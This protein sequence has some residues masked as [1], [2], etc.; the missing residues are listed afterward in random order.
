MLAWGFGWI[1]PGA[2]QLQADNQTQA[3]IVAVAAPDCVTRFEHQTDAVTSWHAL[4]KSADNYN[5]DDYI[6]KGG[7]AMVPKQKP[8]SNLVDAV[9]DACANQLLAL[10]QLNG[11]TLISAKSSAD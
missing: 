7:W 3:A 2:A 6:E 8:D 1:S 5:Q 10:K 11:V 9:A 4:K